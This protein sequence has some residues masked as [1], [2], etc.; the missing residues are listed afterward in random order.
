MEESQTRIRLQITRRRERGITKQRDVQR[1]H[2]VL[3][4]QTLDSFD[5]TVG[6]FHKTLNHIKETFPSKPPA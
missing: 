2:L 5:T 6:S 4:L 3:D 1:K